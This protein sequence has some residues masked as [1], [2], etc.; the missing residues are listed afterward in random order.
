LVPR[1]ELVLREPDTEGGLPGAWVAEEYQFQGALCRL[2]VV[3]FL[4]LLVTIRRADSLW[5]DLLKHW[6]LIVGGGGEW[7][8]C[9]AV[10]A[11]TAG[12]G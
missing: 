7:V 3:L 10:T 2:I 8:G 6:L 5:F 1:G 9:G 12:G 4:P 11:S